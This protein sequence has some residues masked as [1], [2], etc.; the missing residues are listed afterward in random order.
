[1]KSFPVIFSLHP[2][3]LKQIVEKPRIITVEIRFWNVS[4]HPVGALI[5]RSTYRST[6]TDQLTT[7]KIVMVMAQ[8]TTYVKTIS[9]NQ[10]SSLL[11]V[12][13]K[14]PGPM[15]L[16]LPAS[17]THTRL[18]YFSFGHFVQTTWAFVRILKI[19]INI[20]IFATIYKYVA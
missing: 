18:M 10:V 9:G 11:Q 20:L 5:L 8:Q 6:Y 14:I 4:D 17:E 12:G 1:M 13:A 19:L 16:A 7:V 2:V 15:V 3:T